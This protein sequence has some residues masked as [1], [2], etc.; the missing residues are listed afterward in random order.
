MIT[1]KYTKWPE[2]LPNGQNIYQ[3]A[4]IFTKWPEY[5]PNGQNIYQMA[6]K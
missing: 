4:R 2:Y 6:V 5:L 1:I 3:M